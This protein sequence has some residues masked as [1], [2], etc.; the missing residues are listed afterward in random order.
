MCFER[1]LVQKWK[2]KHTS[3]VKVLNINHINVLPRND[4]H[5]KAAI[6]KWLMGFPPKIKSFLGFTSEI[7][8]LYS[9][10][11]CFSR[12][13]SSPSVWT[14]SRATNT[15]TFLLAAWF[16]EGLGVGRHYGGGIKT[17]LSAFP[18]RNAVK[19]CFIYV[20]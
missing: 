13:N 5:K 1:V 14:A 9:F 20:F 10:F 12:R 16:S 15:L 2:Q 3:S 19:G 6:K 7:A 18:L 11:F 8:F 4:G 17:W